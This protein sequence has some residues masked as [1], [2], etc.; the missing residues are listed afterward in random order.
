LF[1][2]ESAK[3]QPTRGIVYS[4]GPASEGINVGDTVYYGKYSGTEVDLAKQGFRIVRDVECLLVDEGDWHN[5]I[6]NESGNCGYPRV[7]AMI[8]GRYPVA[9][10]SDD[11]V[12]VYVRYL[13]NGL[14]EGVFENNA[15]L[16][17]KKD[18]P[19]LWKYA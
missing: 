15:E 5:M 7:D 12:T 1:I 3:E 10:G 19:P 4:I 14:V 16:I 2:P 18:F 11:Y 8:F 6:P 13:A 17:G 9:E